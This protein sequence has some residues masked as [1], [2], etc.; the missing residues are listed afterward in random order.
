M[1]SLR[2]SQALLYLF[3]SER[4]LAR[5][6]ILMLLLLVPIVGWLAVMGYFLRVLSRWMEGKYEGIP[7]FSDFGELIADGFFLAVLEIAYS[8]P[9][10]VLPFV[11]CF[12]NALASLWSLLFLFI[13]PY[14]A[15]VVAR[16]GTIPSEAFDFKR[17]ANFIGD[18]VLRILVVL[19][20]NLVISVGVTVVSAPFWVGGAIAVSVFRRHA[21]IFSPFAAALFGAA[22]VVM[23]FGGIYLMFVAYALWGD[24]WGGWL[25]SG[26]AG[27]PTSAGTSGEE[28]E[29]AAA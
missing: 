5:V 13:L 11:P 3:R 18:N 6:L 23:A 16:T 14:L 8:I 27:E 28:G 9:A 2:V 4:W 26:K 21:L 25:S 1:E 17:V 12:G 15:G 20:V 10:F 24:I 19:A 22:A 29:G 7:D